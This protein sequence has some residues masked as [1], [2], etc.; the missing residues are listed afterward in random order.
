LAL[1]GL[2][3]FLLGFVRRCNEAGIA[4]HLL[5]IGADDLPRP[6]KV[7]WLAS[8]GGTILWS[9]IG[10]GAALERVVSFIRAVGADAICTVEELSLLWLAD[11]RRLFEPE[12]SLMAP[13]TQAIHRLM[14]KSEQIRLARKAGFPLLE[15]W[16][17]HSAAD[18]TVIPDGAF[19]ICLRPT[20]I[21]SVKPAFKAKL[22]D[23]PDALR[24]LLAS[25]S[26]N[27]SP[28]VAQPYCLGPNIVLHAVRSM[29]GEIQAMEAF[30]AYRKYDRLALSLERYTLPDEILD[31]ARRFAELAKI[32][33]PFHFDLL[34]SADTGEV[35]FL[36]IIYRMGGTSAKVQGLG[37]DEPMLAL[38]SFGLVP[39]RVPGQLERKSKATSIRTLVSRILSVLRRPP[40]PM[41]YPQTSRLRVAVGN[42]REIVTVPDPLISWRDLK[43]TCLYLFR[44]MNM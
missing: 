26:W 14:D 13:S 36:E 28:L 20:R 11:N 24:V 35:F 38:S 25:Q 21:N 15:S 23:S 22:L 5:R 9:Q 27:G 29:S 42:L 19:P 7:P 4:V 8:Y 34:Q 10:T 3:P 37:Y 30:R 16:W 44:G 40:D 43:G 17:L 41:D 2:W 18:T 12:C 32:N 31:S 39:P 1:L 6:R 33:G